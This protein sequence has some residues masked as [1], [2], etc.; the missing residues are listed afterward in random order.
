MEQQAVNNSFLI[1]SP[2]D[3]E[4]HNSIS[5][6]KSD[7]QKF[8]YSF[9]MFGIGM[10]LPWNVMLAAMGYFTDKFPDYQP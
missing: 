7:L 8:K 2:S 3:D 10:L 6:A 1:K 5:E 4:N 9:L